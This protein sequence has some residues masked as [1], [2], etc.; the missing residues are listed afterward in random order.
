[1]NKNHKIKEPTIEDIFNNMPEYKKTIFYYLVG[2][3]S[4]L[5]KGKAAK[6]IIEEF[7][8]DKTPLTV[9]DI[10]YEYSDE[11]IK[12]LSIFL[13]K[14]NNEHNLEDSNVDKK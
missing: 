7:I 2:K 5:P 13:E 1:M 12:L 9:D 11:E 10:L 3:A 4:E 8:N 14:A 6:D